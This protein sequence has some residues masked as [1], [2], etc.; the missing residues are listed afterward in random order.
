MAWIEE[1][2]YKGLDHTLKCREHQAAAEREVL[3][4]RARWNGHCETCHGTGKNGKEFCSECLLQKRCP[5][6]GKGNICWNPIS[7]CFCRWRLGDTPPQW[8]SRCLCTEKDLQE[9]SERR[10][11]LSAPAF[12]R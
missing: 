6:C 3:S 8:P 4:W 7:C 5:R 10:Y 11:A 2:D 1:E 12:Y 9:Q